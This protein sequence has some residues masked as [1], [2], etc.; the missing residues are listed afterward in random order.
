MVA[1]GIFADI[2]IWKSTMGG[3]SAIAGNVEEVV[4][5]NRVIACMSIPGP[6][7]DTVVA[8]RHRKTLALRRSRH[9][10]RDAARLRR[11]H[12]HY[13]RHETASQVLFIVKGAMTCWNKL[14]LSSP[15]TPVLK[16]DV[17]T[18]SNC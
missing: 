13:H 10:A 7:A 2:R 18:Q 4:P 14:S 17:P 1:I 6:S 3:T 16:P 12:G 9:K 5:E 15:N 11:R 8:T